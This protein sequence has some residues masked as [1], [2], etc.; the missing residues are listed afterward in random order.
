MKGSSNNCL[1]WLLT[2]RGKPEK[3]SVDPDCVTLALAV[4]K[5]LEIPILLLEAEDAFESGD[6]EIRTRVGLGRKNNE[7]EN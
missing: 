3:L 1:L 4:N 6:V 5:G 2:G 7:S